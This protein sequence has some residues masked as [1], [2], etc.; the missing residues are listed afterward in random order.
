MTDR[1]STVPISHLSMSLF[2]QV[3]LV[4]WGLGIYDIKT[5]CQI[6]RLT[7]F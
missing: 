5:C 2:S 6:I 3:V 7:D 1:F 4:K